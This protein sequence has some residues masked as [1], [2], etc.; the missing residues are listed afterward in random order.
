MKLI[1]YIII[2]ATSHYVSEY[3]YFVRADLLSQPQVQVLANTFEVFQNQPKS[4]YDYSKM[5][6]R[7]RSQQTL[8]YL[9]KIFNC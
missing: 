8:C 1:L 6:K 7:V 5:T 9:H 3:F 4:S 2:I